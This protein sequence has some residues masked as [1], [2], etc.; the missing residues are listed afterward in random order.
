MPPL[1]LQLRLEDYQVEAIDAVRDVRN[2]GTGFAVRLSRQQVISGIIDQWITAHAEPPPDPSAARVIV[3]PPEAVE[4]LGQ[5]T[6]EVAA[7]AHETRTTATAVPEG[8]PQA[9][10]LAVMPDATDR[11]EGMARLEIA[12]VSGCS[13]TQ[14]DSALYK[15]RQSGKIR[16]VEKGRYVRSA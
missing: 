7:A 6:A 15:L 2:H 1:P 9:R 3:P 14:T 16:L 5:L 4:L 13:E 10:V 12:Q 11:P 8:A